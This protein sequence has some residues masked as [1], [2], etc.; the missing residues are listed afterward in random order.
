MASQPVR[1]F[2]AAR[3]RRSVGVQA[4]A[5]ALLA[6]PILY[7]AVAF[8]TAPPQVAY[9][10]DSAFITIRTAKTFSERPKQIPIGRIDSMTET[11]LRTGS[12]RFGTDSPGYCVG[13]FEY[14]HLGEVWQATDCSPETIIIEAGGETH[15][16]AIAPA[17]REAFMA[18]VRGLVPGTFPTSAKPL[19]ISRGML[20]ALVA[21]CWPLA[22]VFAFVGVMAPRG[23]RY[24]IAG[25][26]LEAAGMFA[27]HAVQLAGSKAR[28]HQPLVGERLSGVGFPGYAAG[29]WIM[30]TAPTSV[31][32]TGKDDGVLVEG[33]TRLFVTPADRAEF[34][35]ALEA[36]GAF[37]R[38]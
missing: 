3:G 12:L 24:R 34:L 14:P 35:A 33:D 28:A 36:E 29:A 18:A 30:D 17:D 11:V 13:F 32:G 26:R 21:V 27:R 22:A 38:R 31:L 9:D 1:E 19:G 37:V 5:A 10:V 6:A 4:L 15:P 2:V 7:G 23:V 8:M 20:A 25:G 16:V